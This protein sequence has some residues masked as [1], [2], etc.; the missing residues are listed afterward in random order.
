MKLMLQID[1]PDSQS[2]RYRHMMAA[3]RLLAGL[4]LQAGA[5]PDPDVK[6]PIRDDRGDYA[7]Y[8]RIITPESVL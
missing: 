7:G 1:L 4:A 2:G 8:F 3:R 5:M 6:A